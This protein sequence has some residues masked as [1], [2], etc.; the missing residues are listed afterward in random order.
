MCVQPSSL[1]ARHLD[2][3]CNIYSFSVLLLEIVTGRPLICKDKGSL[4]G[5]AKDYLE[6]P[7]KTTSVVDPALKH[8]KVE[9]LEEIR[10]LPPNN[11]VELVVYKNEKQWRIKTLY[12]TNKRE[13]H[14]STGWPRFIRD[15]DIRVDD[16]LIIDLV[17]RELNITKVRNP[18]LATTTHATTHE[19]DERFEMSGS[20]RTRS[21]AAIDSPCETETALYEEDLSKIKISPKEWVCPSCSGKCQ[22]KGCRGKP[23]IRD[24]DFLALDD[25]PESSSPPPSNA[26]DDVSDLLA[27]LGREE[28]ASKL[29]GYQEEEEE[30]IPIYC[31]YRV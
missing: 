7:E 24:F 19:P 20:Y 5:W 14:L 25:V 4:V 3:H 12:K 29:E 27:L 9:D 21:K 22:C 17:E 1:Q 2:I 28:E 16:I 26:I 31:N 23:T 8:F 30:D 6:D 10:E 13:H 15:N 18:T 11:K